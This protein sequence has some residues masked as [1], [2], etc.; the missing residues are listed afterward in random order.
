M[1]EQQQLDCLERTRLLLSAHSTRLPPLTAL[2]L[3]FDRPYK[4]KL[5]VPGAGEPVELVIYQKK[6][7]EQGFASTGGPQ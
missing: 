7:S 3:R 5:A 1:R 4:H 6:F 2:R